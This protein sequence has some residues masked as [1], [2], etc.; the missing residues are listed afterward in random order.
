M[1]RAVYS[2]LDYLADIGGLFNA[3]NGLAF[4]T[5]YVMT[6]HGVYHKLTSTMYSVETDVIQDKKLELPKLS[7]KNLL[8]M[9]VKKKL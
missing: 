6:Y 2:L 9:A 8:E 4:V 3:I 5:N 7:S 1:S